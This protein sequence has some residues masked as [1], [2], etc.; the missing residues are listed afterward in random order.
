MQNCS[1]LSHSTCPQPLRSLGGLDISP[2]IFAHAQ[3]QV[4]LRGF[5]PY[6]RSWSWFFLSRR[7]RA[8]FPVCLS[9]NPSHVRSQGL[10]RSLSIWVCPV[11]TL[12][13]WS[14]RCPGVHG[15]PVSLTSGFC[16]FRPHFCVTLCF[17]QHFVTALLTPGGVRRF[18]AAAPQPLSAGWGGHCLPLTAHGLYFTAT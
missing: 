12:A 6:R 9:T 16:P 8:I 5:L 15:L 17:M 18:I 4:L 2:H 13:M 1:F 3:R 7:Q 11:S 10:L 14:E